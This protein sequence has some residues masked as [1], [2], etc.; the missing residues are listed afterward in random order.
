MMATKSRAA[1]PFPNENQLSLFSDLSE[2]ELADNLGKEPVHVGNGNAHA[3]RPSDLGTLET[4]PPQDGGEPGERESPS[5]SDLR[6]TGIDQQSPVRV[7]GSE[8]DG[9]PPGL[10]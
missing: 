6:S 3:S 2:P 10:G 7:D 1:S 5:A 9:I 8:K 4:P